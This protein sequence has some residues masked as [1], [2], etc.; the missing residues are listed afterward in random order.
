MLPVHIE[1]VCDD[2][3]RTHHLSG[4]GLHLS[5]RGT[6]EEEAK[7]YNFIQFIKKFDFEKDYV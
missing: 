2:S 6:C 4:S 1:L 5:G 7:A 3:I